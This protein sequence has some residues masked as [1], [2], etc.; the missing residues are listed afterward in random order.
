MSKLTEAMQQIEP[1][2]RADQ[3][4]GNHWRG[5]GTPRLIAAAVLADMAEVDAMMREI[6][7]ATS[8]PATED[9]RVTRAV[10]VAAAEMRQLD[11]SAW[12][13]FLTRLLE[14]LAPHAPD[15]D[16]RVALAALRDRITARL[17]GG[18]W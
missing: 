16:Y 5:D 3:W 10:D 11:P 18:G 17:D 6:A 12:L 1:L 7:R 9:E 15:A 4:D 14:E 2:A 13:A 8:L